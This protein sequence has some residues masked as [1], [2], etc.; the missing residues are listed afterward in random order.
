MLSFMKSTITGKSLVFIS[1]FMSCLAFAQEH[2][3]PNFDKDAELQKFVERGGKVEVVSPN[4]FSLTYPTGE[5]RILNFNA[6]LKVLNNYTLPN[7]IIINVGDIDTSKYSGKFHFWQKVK[8]V[9]EYE[10]TIPVED[11]NNNGL[12]ELYGFNEISSVYAG[13]V[14]IYEQNDQGIFHKVYTYDTNTIFVQGIGDVD[15][16]GKKEIHLRTLDTLNGEFYK[17]DSPDSL[18]T[19]FDFVFYYYPYP[20]QIDDLTFGFF[21]KNRINDCVFTSS[22][23]LALPAII[24]GEFRDGLNNFTTIYEQITGDTNWVNVPS[25]F[26]MGDFDGDTRIEIVS[27]T[28]QGIVYS[29]EAVKENQYD[30]VWQGSAPTYNAYM[31][32]STNDID[33]NGKPEFWI[34]GQNFSTGIS[35]FWCYE[36]NGD[37]SYIPV[38]EIQL[39]Y[40]V[41][42][43]ANYLQAADMDNDGTDEL[44]ISLGNYM[45]ILKFTGKP[46]HH[47]Y[48]ISYAKINESTQPGAQFHPVSIKDFN[49]DGKKD[50]LLPMDK[51]VNPNIDLFSYLLVQDSVTSIKYE[52]TQVP[53]K[54]ELRQNFPN[55]FNPTTTVKFRLGIQSRIN[56]S[57]Y[58]VL[59]KEIK[60]LAEATLSAGEYTYSWDGKDNEGNSLPGGI[61]F[62]QM[63]AQS[64][65]KTIK[66]VLLK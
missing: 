58:N 17:S 23:S 26:A 38:A 43:G 15:S 1:L 49:Q 50:I 40:L 37:N 65:R 51:Y 4:I 33:K 31:I 14:V 20:G 6:S 48:A 62:I 18:P 61:Y 66:A 45:I 60:T 44:I 53:D 7:P 42:L 29:I 13:P 8:I 55:P 5:T 39:R 21:D 59:G 16:D 27:G 2:K 35:T 46:N 19:L 9:N 57:V 11:L 32:T 25:G 24:I 30:L 34:G 52:N 47:Q 54:F 56:L 36:S 64:F 12:L 22:T 28:T 10:R 41:T 63:K 3:P